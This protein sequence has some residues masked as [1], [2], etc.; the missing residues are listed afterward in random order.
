MLILAFVYY[1]DISLRHN[2]IHR[3]LSPSTQMHPIENKDTHSQVYRYMNT[4]LQILY[5]IQLYYSVY[6]VHRIYH[7]AFCGLLLHGNQTTLPEENTMYACVSVS[8]SMCERD[9]Q[10][11]FECIQYIALY[12]S[13]RIKT[14]QYSQQL[15][16]LRCE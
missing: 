7:L 12:P 8:V 14:I 13:K 1:D 5:Y 11:T 6:C 3:L 9:R 4:N 16:S 2:F 15:I 10:K